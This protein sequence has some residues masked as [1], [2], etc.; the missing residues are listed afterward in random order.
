MRRASLNRT[1]Q[2]PARA[3]EDGP[4]LTYVPAG[5]GA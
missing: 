5:C 4:G 1:R 2:S 3:T